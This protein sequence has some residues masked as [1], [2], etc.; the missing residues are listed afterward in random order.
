MKSRMKRAVWITLL[1][2]GYWATATVSR[3]Q[4]NSYISTTDGFWDEA[5]LWSLA[6]PPSVS[7]SG[8]LITNAASVTVTIDSITANNFPSTLTISNLTLLPPFGSTNTLYLDNTGTNGTTRSAKNDLSVWLQSYHGPPAGASSVISSNSTLI[9]D[10]ELGGA[11]EDDGTLVFIGG[12]LITTNSSIEVGVSV[13]DLGEPAGLLIISNAVVQALNLGIATKEPSI[14]T[15][16][17]FGGT[18]TLSSTLTIDNNF[19]SRTG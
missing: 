11:L 13:Y 19:L 7:Q 6:E 17:L 14:G 2:S 12:S 5:R 1:V 4:T 16:D 10:G 9:V 15:V 8:I 3:A 18:M